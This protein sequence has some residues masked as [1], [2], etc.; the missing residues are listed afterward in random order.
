[1]DR[2]ADGWLLKEIMAVSIR[3]MFDPIIAH[4]ARFRQAREGIAA[5]EFALILP[6]MATMW[7]GT[8]EVGQAVSSNRKL[9]LASRTLA[10]LTARATTISNTEMNTIFKATVAVFAPFPEA[11]LGKVVTSIKCISLSG[12]GQCNNQVVWSNFDGPGV[13]ARPAG[14]SI[15]LPTGLLTQINQTIILA[16]VKYR[17]MPVVGWVVAK[18]GLDVKEQTY[19]VPRQVPEVVRVP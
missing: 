18:T 2:R 11:Q 13:A 16:E 5:V 10:D 6:L 1:V 8:I 7:L 9:V 15:V 12:G 19:M 14:S 3:K 4:L 17:Y